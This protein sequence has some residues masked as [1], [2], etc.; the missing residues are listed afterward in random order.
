MTHNKYY[1]FVILDSGV[2][3][4]HKALKNPN[5][6]DCF[7]C[8]FDECNKVKLLPPKGD[9][10]GHGTA[11]SAIINKAHPDASVMMIEI[12]NKE[13]LLSVGEE[14]LFSVLEYIYENIEGKVINLS[15]GIVT[16]EHYEQFYRICKK[17]AEK[18]F[19][20]VSA[21]DNGGAISYPASFDCVIGVDTERRC[22]R[23]D[24]FVY[25]TND[26]VVNI[27]A[28]G[29]K[30]RVA[31]SGP[32][33]MVVAGSSFACAHVSTQVYRFILEGITGYQN[34]LNKFK[35]IAIGSYDYN[36]DYHTPSG[37]PF[38]IR[39]AVIFPFNKE[40]H[41]II[42][43]AADLDFEIADV[44]DTKYSMMVGSTTDH[45]MRDKTVLSK[46]I[47]NISQID[48]SSFDTLILGHF[49]ELSEKIHQDNI[50]ANILNTAIENGKN[51]YSFDDISYLL[52]D[53]SY[54]NV[55]FPAV[56]MENVPP[57]R[58]GKLAVVDKPVLGIMGTGSQQGK[59]T[60]Q[61]ELRKRLI[62]KGY[63]V[64]QIGTEPSALLYGMDYAF[65]M[66]YKNS[67]YTKEY[68]T[69]R[70]LNN[71]IWDLSQKDIE[72]I[73]VGGQAG[74]APSGFEN[75]MTYYLP[76]YVFLLGTL[77]D[78][79]VLVVNP[80]DSDETIKRSIDFIE[81]SIDAG[82][83]ALV[84][85]PMSG[86]NGWYAFEKKFRITAE[87]YRQIKGHLEK[88]FQLPVFLLGEEQE[89]DDLTEYI[90]GCFAQQ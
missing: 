6:I 35:E 41:N 18:G 30:Q 61:L 49:D 31:W 48:W 32:E 63:K 46:T 15:L 25:Y 19:I 37:Y 21:F 71:C 47:K 16:T 73:L 86:G 45:V 87:D 22:V 28:M 59:F 85:F 79:T 66:G 89:F 58:N 9:T 44:Y 77:P 29:G 68:D 50:V 53:K 26:S 80:N 3:L 38:K 57:Y 78:A 27:G 17:L 84:V 8:S 52:G 51:I 76:Q 83:V 5:V 10:E 82:V 11:V 55:Y 60:L 14:S 64:G 33:Y 90:I 4:E 69:V 62:K 23:S 36:T 24:Q 56:R 43:F 70:Y 1:D 20:I 74:T 88:T 65:P 12:F 72:I 42:R 34:I 39:K 2:N 13:K 54:S 67:V 7:S 75:T 81:S 40:M